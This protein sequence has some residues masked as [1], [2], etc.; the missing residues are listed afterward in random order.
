MSEVTKYFGSALK[1]NTAFSKS[2][3]KLKGA[4]LIAF[5]PIYEYVV[6]A[7]TTLI[8]LLTRAVQ[9]IGQFLAAI[10]GKS[11]SAMA[12]N[13]AGLHELAAGYDEAGGAAKD[14]Q[15][16]FSGLD[17]VNVYSSSEQGGGG[18]AAGGVAP[19]FAVDDSIINLSG[20]SLTKAAED[21]TTKLNEMISNVDWAAIGGK[22]AS[23]IDNVLSFIATAIL[24]FDWFAAASGVGELLN[25]IINNVD[26]QNLGVILG[27]KF[28]IL[29]EGLGGLFST[30][31]WVGL[32]VALA[33]ALM[34]LWNAID[35]VQAA[36][37]L[38][39]GL[40]GAISSLS[41][42]IQNIDWQKIGNDIA[43]FIAHIDWNGLFVALSEGIGAALAGLALL[44]WGLIED[45]WEDVVSW[46][47]DVAF[48]DGKFTMKGLLNG[49]KEVFK[50]IDTW[51]KENIFQPFINGFKN[52]FGIHS[53]STVMHEQGVFII[54]GLLQGIKNTWTSITSFFS[55]ALS[56][57]GTTI[58]NGWTNIRNNAVTS[59]TN[60][61]NKLIST[62]SSIKTGASNMWNNI[63]T[64]VKGPINSIIGAI[65]GMI[66]GVVS[67]INTVIRALN[68]L[69]FTIPS[70][71][72]AYGGRS[73]GFNISTLTAPQ[74]PYLAKGAV[75]PPNAPF[76]AVLGDQRNG[77]NLEAPESLIRKIV[78]EEAGGGSQGGN[79]R[80]VAQINRRTLFEEIIEEA[81][82]R[83]DQ[84]GQNPFA[85]A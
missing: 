57:L 53:P 65:N 14:A 84:N 16:I 8:N 30:I 33:S 77:K 66:S 70:W 85:L 62:W 17:E 21:L 80:F 45:A 1:A 55:T 58:S 28:I 23:G 35:W 61:K 31:D 32:G 60:I 36:A 7:I 64:A 83:R 78:K 43:S 79:W 48:E 42:A 49:I 20:G 68:R 54:Q 24:N 46:W 41:T 26:W 3:A 71:V 76:T 6:P 34:G 74:I 11:Y 44:L 72:P 4:L 51:I 39:S 27:A 47:E 5:Q 56:S 25:E 73:F 67:G 22:V 15:K 2:F 9:A 38:S 19:D 12:Q 75:I 59:W 29:I 40:I 82:L 52:V 18:G 50:N 69:S 81:K 63:V 10:T 13:A 37:T